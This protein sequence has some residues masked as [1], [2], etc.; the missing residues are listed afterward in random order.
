VLFC[1]RASLAFDGRSIRLQQEVH[2]IKTKERKPKKTKEN[3]V[4]HNRFFRR[5]KALMG[6]KVI[7]IIVTYA[8]F[9][10]PWFRQ[11]L[12]WSGTL[13]DVLAGL[14]LFHLMRKVAGTTFVTYSVKLQQHQKHS[15]DILRKIIHLLVDD[16]QVI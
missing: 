14:I 4:I 16:A 2:S 10:V 9:K 11:V 15:T 1:V 7:L 5:L 12:N 3:K 13:L 6:D 8:A